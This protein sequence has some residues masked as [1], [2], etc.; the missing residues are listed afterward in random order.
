MPAIYLPEG[1]PG[2]ESY[3]AGISVDGNFLGW[4]ELRDENGK[5]MTDL[6]RNTHV[7]INIT[8]NL[9]YSDFKINYTVCPWQT[10]EIDIP[11]FD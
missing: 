4:A 10:E 3:H 11:D 9:E 7:V 8:L 1:R 5:P 2:T 6:P